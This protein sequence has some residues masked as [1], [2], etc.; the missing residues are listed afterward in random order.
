MS[1][2]GS[3]DPQGRPLDAPSPRRRA[4]G[5]LARLAA[6]GRLPAER[7]PGLLLSERPAPDGGVPPA[8]GR[9]LQRD[10]GDSERDAGRQYVN[11]G[12][13]LQPAEHGH[14]PP[15]TRSSSSRST[16]GTSARSRRR[17]LHADLQ[18]HQCRAGRAARGAGLRLPAARHPGHRHL[19]RRDLHARRPRRQGCRVPG[20]E[21]AEVHG[22]RA[23]AAGVRQALYDL[24]RRVSR[25]SSPEWTATRC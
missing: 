14:V 9:G 7:R 24:A 12:C 8:H 10:R 22:G 13:R 20:R 25:K 21:H 18:N 11:D 23:Q 16:P 2:C 17:Q 4:R 5:R 6:A 15:T 19:G 1:V 3:S